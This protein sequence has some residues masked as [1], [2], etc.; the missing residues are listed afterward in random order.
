VQHNSLTLAAQRA[1]TDDRLRRA[2]Q[3]HDHPAQRHRSQARARAAR[4]LAVSARKLDH[5]AARRA[6]AR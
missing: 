2:R 3:H 6:L 4:A 5:H 1:A